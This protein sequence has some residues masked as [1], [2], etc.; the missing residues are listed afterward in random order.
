MVTANKYEQAFEFCLKEMFL[1]VGEKYPNKSL[2]SQPK[3]YTM[4]SWTIEEA[5]E[6]R[7]WM[8]AYLRKKLRLNKK[9]AEAEIA[10]FLMQYGW[11]NQFK[12]HIK[13]IR[14]ES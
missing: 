3:W 2:T 14:H 6:F 7:Q 5:N 1:R 9:R 12:F 11:T 8:V 13:A 10:Y 4:R